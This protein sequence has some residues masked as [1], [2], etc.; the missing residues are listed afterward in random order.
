M[1]VT[2]IIYLCID[3]WQ[4]YRNANHMWEEE[5]AT[6]SEKDSWYGKGIDYWQKVEP[7]VDGVLG[8]FGHIS[9]TD[10]EHSRGFLN[11]VFGE[12]ID[13]AI[14]NGQE[15]VAAGRIQSTKP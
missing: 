15:L 12:N 14:N 9:P 1:T 4:N 13:D 5:V 6:P 2:D 10:V 3:G 11:K 8:G 7:S